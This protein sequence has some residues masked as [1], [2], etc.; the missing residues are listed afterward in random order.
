MRQ[1]PLGAK[2]RDPVCCSTDRQVKTSPLSISRFKAVRGSR[3]AGTTR[4]RLWFR[5]ASRGQTQLG[6]AVTPVAGMQ[7]PRSAVPRK[8]GQTMGGRWIHGD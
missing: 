5:S 8:S 7:W 3:A 6:V 4:T 1:L 2:V